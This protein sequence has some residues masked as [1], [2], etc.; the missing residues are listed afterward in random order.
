MKSLKKGDIL[1]LLATDP[2]AKIDVAHFCQENNHALRDQTEAAG[3][4]I[5]EI[6]K[7]AG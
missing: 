7:E 3:V 1:R 6:E 5:F 2:M 4:L